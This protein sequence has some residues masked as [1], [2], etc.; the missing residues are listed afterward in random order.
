MASPAKRAKLSGGASPEIAALLSGL[1]LDGDRYV[2]LLT[3]LITE[4]EFVQNFPPRHVPEEDKV[5]A[6]LLEQ[7]NPYSTE[8]GGVL[9]IQHVHF[10]EKR[11]NLII[12]YQPE[13]AEGTVAFVGSHLDVVPAN[14]E[15]W[16]VPP[17][18]LTRSTP[19]QFPAEADGDRLY[20]RGTTDC[21][22]HVALIT[23]MLVEIAKNKP[24]LKK[25][26][27]VCFIASEE[28]ATIAEVGV[29]MVMKNH[30]LD[31]I[32]GGPVYW[33]DSADS[34]PCIGTAAA[35]QWKLRAEGKQF[36]S[37][38][39]HKGINA[40]EFGS[41]AVAELQKR[42]YRDFPAHEQEA[43]YAFSSASTMKPTRSSGPDN[44]VNQVPAWYEVEGDI[45]LTPF[46]NAAACVETMKKHVA[47][48]NANPDSLSGSR[49]DFSKYIIQEEDTPEPL[50]GKITWEVSGDVFKGIACKLDSPGYK[51]LC[52]ATDAVKGSHKAYSI[53]GSLP[54]VGDL[55]EAGFDVQISGYG[56]SSV[57]HCDNEYCLLSDMKD[58][59][60]ILMQCIILNE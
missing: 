54:L 21:L 36:H 40:L 41:D 26:L 13:G 12:D 4:A 58:A 51:A 8:N 53:C 46:Y 22:G 27:C 10:K 37:G 42:F 45:R 25:N 60:K 20:G 52:D 9:K 49:G 35:I 29:D 16:A 34:Q 2:A 50:K 39:P 59:F 48:L 11:G 7:L 15:D 3:K 55:Q 47:D 23:E 44:S 24:A 43:V 38:L 19:G 56:K 32:K 28:N 5:I 14:P 30:Y 6:H 17:F 31:H 18:K 1:S 33:I 57:Y